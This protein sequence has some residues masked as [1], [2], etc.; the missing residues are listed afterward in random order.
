MGTLYV[1][2]SKGKTIR[3][4]I[5]AAR[6]GTGAISSNG[7]G[8]V[9]LGGGTFAS[10][11]DLVAAYPAPAVGTTASI[12]GGGVVRYTATGWLGDLGVFADDTAAQAALAVAA[13]GS[14]AYTQAGAIWT[15]GA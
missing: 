9:S 4:L 2:S 11:A 12:S 13:N 10:Y 7:D 3:S 15:K 1:N 14:R 5:Q 6:N 8:T